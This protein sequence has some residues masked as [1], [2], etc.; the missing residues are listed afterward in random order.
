MPTPEAKREPEYFHESIKFDPEKYGAHL[1]EGSIVLVENNLGRPFLMKKEG[2]IFVYDG[3]FPPGKLECTFLAYPS[4]RLEEPLEFPEKGQKEIYEFGEAEEV[5]KGGQVISLADHRAGVRKSVASALGEEGEQKV[6][7]EEFV[8]TGTDIDLMRKRIGS[9]AR[10]LFEVV[11]SPTLDKD[12]AKE[13]RTAKIE[14]RE[15]LRDYAKHGGPEAR[16]FLLKQNVRM[17]NLAQREWI[18][19][20]DDLSSNVKDLL[21]TLQGRLKFRI[22]TFNRLCE[23]GTLGLKKRSAY[24][25]VLDEEKVMSHFKNKLGKKLD[26]FNRIC[27]SYDGESMRAFLDATAYD[28]VSKH[29]P[30]GRLEG[31]QKRSRSRRDLERTIMKRNKLEEGAYTSPAEIKWYTKALS[32]GGGAALKIAAILTI[33]SNPLLAIGMYGAKG[34]TEAV[35][36]AEFGK[37]VEEVAKLPLRL[38]GKIGKLLRYLPASLKE[39]LPEGMQDW[40]E[41]P[42]GALFGNIGRAKLPLKER[43]KLFGRGLVPLPGL[44]EKSEKLAKIVP[45][46]Q[47]RPGEAFE[48]ATAEAEDAVDKATKYALASLT[49]G[50]E[51][52][53]LRAIAA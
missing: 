42:S 5:N 22:A 26:V 45:E 53:H 27:S 51:G 18:Y 15:L 2:D 52:S 50:K 46:P 36:G 14:H 44:L 40:L 20:R 47:M 28:V 8:T 11:K 13:I 1:P 24:R 25:G 35:T 12:A 43:L 3:V 23:Q 21:S 9:S 33:T 19:G 34:I 30:D 32:G 39:K 10:G 6:E 38:P 4:G 48:E 31:F 49:K 7:K 41:E 16:D 37:V 17:L 29:I